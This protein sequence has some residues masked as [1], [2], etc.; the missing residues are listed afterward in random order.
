MATLTPQDIKNGTISGA[1]SAVATKVIDSRDFTLATPLNENYVQNTSAY[2]YVVIENANGFG[3]IYKTSEIYP[4]ENITT[5][6]QLHDALNLKANRGKAYKL[7][8]DIDCEGV[9]WTQDS[10]SNDSKNDKYSIFTGYFDGNGHKISNLNISVVNVEGGGLF[11]KA[12]KQAIIKNLALEEV[13]V[14]ASAGTEVHKKTAILVGD[15]KG[16]VTIENIYI[17]NCGVKSYERVAGIVGQYSGSSEAS[18]TTIRNVVIT[19]TKSGEKYSI[20]ASYTSTGSD[21]TVTS[22]GGKYVGG[23]LAHCQFDGYGEGSSLVIENCYVNMNLIASN[24]FAAGILGRVD[25]KKGATAIKNCVFAGEISTTNNYAA[26]IIAGRASGQ[27]IQVSNTVSRGL[28]VAEKGGIGATISQQMCNKQTIGNDK[29]YSANDNVVEMTNCYW[30]IPT[31]D[32]ENEK[33]LTEEEHIAA[34]TLKKD[35]YGTPVYSS[36]LTDQSW[37]ESIGFD[38]TNIFVFN[39]GEFKLQYFNKN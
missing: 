28:L 22:A 36:K 13:F 34:E 24:Q 14:N 7:A 20:S 5:A 2:S 27:K 8:N 4:T 19:S 21:G 38:F 10:A 17:L 16:G 30:P 31:Y 11:Y 37:Y 35:Y 29:Y 26:G 6:A 23:I 18:T 12:D 1:I 3:A 33:G 9:T 25:A 15:V 39:K 32:P